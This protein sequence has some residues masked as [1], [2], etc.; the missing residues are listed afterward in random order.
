MRATVVLVAIS[1]LLLVGCEEKAQQVGG[2]AE[3]YAVYSALIN[4][5]YAGPDIERIVIRDHTGVSAHPSLQEELARVSKQMRDGPDSAMVADFSTKNAQEH[6]LTNSF[7]AKVPCVLI[8][9]QELEAI[10]RGRGGW[11]EFYKWYPK[12]Q[13]E[14]TLSRVGFNAKRDRALVYVGNQS[15]WLAGAGY[16]A[17]LEKENGVW[18]VRDKVL[19]WVS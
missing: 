16:Y 4:Q 7:Q 12:S 19:V 1:L 11:D 8:S 15:H 13:G 6:P 14:M 9:Q 3:E 18:R 5:E 10:F 2:E 17:L